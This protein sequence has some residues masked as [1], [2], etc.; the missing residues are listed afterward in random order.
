MK[1][2]NQ[3]QLSSQK[4]DDS[5]ISDPDLVKS[6]YFNYLIYFMIFTLM[7]LKPSIHQ[8]RREIILF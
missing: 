6:F 7:L 3:M 4:K 2:N 8:K 1:T 5:T